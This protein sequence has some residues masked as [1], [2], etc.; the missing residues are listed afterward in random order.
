[1]YLAN[2]QHFLTS[3]IVRMA[4]DCLNMSLGGFWERLLKG[5]IQALSG[6]PAFIL[7]P[8]GNLE[9]GNHRV[10][11]PEQ[12]HEWSLGSY[13][14]DSP[15]LFVSELHAV[16]YEKTNLQ[17]WKGTLSL[18]QFSIPKETDFQSQSG[19]LQW[20]IRA[21]FGVVFPSSSYIFLTLSPTTLLHILYSSPMAS[22][23]CTPGTLPAV[24][25]CTCHSYVEHCSLNVCL[26]NSFTF[27]QGVNQNPFLSAS[28]LVSLS[29]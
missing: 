9:D 12:R 15:G 27:L 20:P 1:M 4:R 5:P 17:F 28:S 14:C 11:K 7:W 8:W 2:I 25:F 24:G 19:S 18:G 10:M 3:I 16:I 13:D 26:V 23:L 22:L 6:V 29:L 21:Q